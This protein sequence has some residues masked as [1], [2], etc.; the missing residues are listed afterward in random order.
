MITGTCHCGAVQWRSEAMPESATTCSCTACR[1]Y[2]ALWAYGREGEDI[3][4]SGSTHT[5]TEGRWVR[6]HFCGECGCMVYWRALKPNASGAFQMGVN[7]RM[8]D[9]EAVAT[10]PINRHDGLN[11]PDNLPRDGRCVADYWF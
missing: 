11:S 5:Y 3:T 7:L 9:P 1:R 6:F 2:G 8:S 10:I 4:V